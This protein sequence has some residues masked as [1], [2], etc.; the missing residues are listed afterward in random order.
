MIKI[1]TY[2]DLLTEKQ[3]LKLLLEERKITLKEDVAIIRETLKPAT[4][5]LTIIGKLTSRDKTNPLINFGLDLGI[6]LI[7]KKL[8]LGRA[9]WISKL[10]VPFILKNLGSNVLAENK[11]LGFLKKVLS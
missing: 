9:G 4:E 8:I 11:K 5:A 1:N 10:I 6:D 3:R 2:Q 7:V